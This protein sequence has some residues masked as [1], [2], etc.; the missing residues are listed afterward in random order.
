MGLVNITFSEF[1]K[2]EPIDEKIS[3][4]HKER[5]KDFFYELLPKLLLEEGMNKEG[6]D[7]FKLPRKRWQELY[8]KIFVRFMKSECL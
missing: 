6:M 7:T 4:E 2:I 1:E 3:D 5:Y 8:C